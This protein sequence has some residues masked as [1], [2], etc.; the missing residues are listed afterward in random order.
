MKWDG[1]DILDQSVYSSMVTGPQG[2]LGVIFPQG[3]KPIFSLRVRLRCCS[4]ALPLVRYL[5][6]NRGPGA[7]EKD[8]TVVASFKKLWWFA[9]KLKEACD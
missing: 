3:F 6:G 7:Q 2:L 5:V 8:H 9:R 4:A 1:L